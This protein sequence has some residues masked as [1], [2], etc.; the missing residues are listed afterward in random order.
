MPF[1]RNPAHGI[2]HAIRRVHAIE[3]LRDFGAQKTTRHRMRGIAAQARCAPEI[4][5]TDQDSA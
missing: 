2:E 4:I 1:R 5:D 3:V